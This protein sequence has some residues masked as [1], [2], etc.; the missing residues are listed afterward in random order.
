MDDMTDGIAVAGDECSCGGTLE[1]TEMKGIW[2]LDCDT[3]HKNYGTYE[4]H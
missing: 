2:S 4:E 1:A 3:C